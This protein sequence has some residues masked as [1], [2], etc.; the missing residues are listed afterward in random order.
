MSSM[1]VVVLDGGVVFGVMMLLLDDVDT[2]SIL[3]YATSQ[4]LKNLNQLLI[5][6]RIRM[7]QE[8]RGF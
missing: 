8:L 6:L 4:C 3:A 1:M 2:F 7:P 5:F